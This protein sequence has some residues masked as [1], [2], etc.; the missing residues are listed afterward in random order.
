MNAIERLR[1]KITLPDGSFRPGAKSRVSECLG[2]SRTT[3]NKWLDY[4]YKPG[5]VAL[6][7]LER[8]LDEPGIY[9]GAIKPGPKSDL[10]KV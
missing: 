6:A 5:K 4:E 7:N 1:Q 10:Q 2:I 9:F 8:L 3:I